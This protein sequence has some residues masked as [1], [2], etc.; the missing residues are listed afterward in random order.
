MLSKLGQPS[1]QHGDR[2]GI[3]ICVRCAM[4]VFSSPFTSL[5]TSVTAAPGGAGG[6]DARLQL[7]QTLT[8]VLSA[9]SA[10][11]WTLES[12]FGMPP[13]A[14]CPLAAVSAVNVQLPLPSALPEADE[15]IRAAESGD[16]AAVSDLAAA[17]GVSPPPAVGR[18]VG[19]SLLLEYPLPRGAAAEPLQLRQS[20][21]AVAAET[22]AQQD[23]PALTVHRFKNACSFW[24]PQL[25][26]SRMPLVGRL[27]SGHCFNV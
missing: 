15:R 3:L 23:R 2:L 17:M 10:G 21:G 14:A 4:Q 12:L 7:V 11:D 19:G 5:G 18:A 25:T 22:W 8:L 1:G 27:C 6:I 20:P 13:G 9:R 24:L 16:A 26:P